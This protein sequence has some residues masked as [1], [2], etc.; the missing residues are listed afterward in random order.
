MWRELRWW[1]VLVTVVI[2][3]MVFALAEVGLEIENP[4]GEGPND[5]DLDRYCNLLALDLDEIMNTIPPKKGW[6]KFD[7]STGSASGSVSGAVTPTPAATP[8]NWGVLVD[9]GARLGAD[10]GDVA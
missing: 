10:I 8:R 2:A 5:L 4:W 1:T 7:I 9:V 6:S 3:Y